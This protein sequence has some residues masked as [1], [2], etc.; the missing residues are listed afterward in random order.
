MGKRHL[1]S[2]PDQITYYGLFSLVFSSFNAAYALLT[3]AGISSIW[4]V[5]VVLVSKCTIPWY[6]TFLPACGDGKMQ[7]LFTGCVPASWVPSN[8]VN[9]VASIGD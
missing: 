9:W 7:A 6:H 8:L 3:R 5:A 4:E 2:I 1:K